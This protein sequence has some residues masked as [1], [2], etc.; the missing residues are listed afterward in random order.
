MLLRTPH[1]YTGDNYVQSS[2]FSALQTA[3]SRNP[4]IFK[5]PTDEHGTPYSVDEYFGYRVFSRTEMDSRLPNATMDQFDACI[6]ERKTLKEILQTISP[7]QYING[8]S[9]E[10]PLTSAIGSNH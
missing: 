6:Q 2:I 8:H 1:M 10:E 9:K 7:T 3:L 5:Q 4:R